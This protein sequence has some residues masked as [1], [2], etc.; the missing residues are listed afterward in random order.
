MSEYRAP[1]T[2]MLFVINELAGL[3]ELSRYSGF[4]EATPDL[5]EAILGE[6]AQLASEVIAPTNRIGDAT[7]TRIEDGQV[8]VAPEFSDAYRQFV[9]GGWAGL[10][11]HPEHGGQGLPFL[12]NIAVEE[13][14]QSANLAWSLCPLLTQGAAHALEAHGSDQL[15]TEYSPKL[16][17]GEWTGTM[18]LSEPQAGSDLAAI[19][20][21]AVPEG[22]HFRVSGQKIFITY[23]DH[24]MTDNVIHLVLARIKDAPE[25]AKGLSLFLVPKRLPDADGNA[26]DLNGVNP[27][28]VEHKLGINGSPTCVLSFENAVGFLLGAENNGLACM[29]TMMN[30][31]RLNVGLEG[32]SIAERAY[33]RALGHARDRVQGNA[34]GHE[35]RVTIIHHPDVR[36]MLMTIKAEIEAMR[37]VAYVTAAVLDRAGHEPDSKL[38]AAYQARLELMTPVVKGWITES[39][40]QLTSIAL[41]IH[42]GTGY[43]EEAGAAQHYRDARIATIY[44]GTTGIQAN[45]LVGRKIIGDGGAALTVLLDEMGQFGE[46]WNP[47]DEL[48]TVRDAYVAAVNEL[49][50]SAAWLLANYKRDATIAGAVSF[51]LLM[52]MGLVAGAWQMARAADRAADKLAQGGQDKEFYSAKLVT[53][54]FYTE[55][56]LPRAS[57]HGSAIRSGGE[58]TMGL[59][60]EQF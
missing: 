8:R 48:A 54:R 20:T 59:G 21:L 30:H 46:Q 1:V 36:R 29:F 3:E 31:A 19:R 40:Q 49:R 18:N 43:I 11:G 26:G 35:G 32:I 6:A 42:G 2:E 28:S 38:R 12:I 27:V 55:Q 5:V 25:G 10:A 4:E 15:R 47:G 51:H 50:E 44:E 53:A 41:Q 39:G 60:E 56:I 9:E 13:M 23:G 14:W 17:S 52:Q 34:A 7:G 57:A 45:D 24:D 58:S 22:D 37:A 16:T 33:Q